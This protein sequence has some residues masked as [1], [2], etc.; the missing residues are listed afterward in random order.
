MS[1]LIY[2]S[3]TSIPRVF[4][5]Y[6]P[7]GLKC[8]SPSLLSSF[9]S[10]SH[11]VMS[12]SLQP[13]W[14]VARQAPLSMGFSRQEYWGGLSSPSPGDLPDSET[15]PRSP[16]LQASSLPYEPF[17]T[18]WA[19]READGVGSLSLLQR[20]FLTQES[21]QGLCIAVGF[22]TSW[23]IREAHPPSKAWSTNPLPWGL[24]PLTTSQVQ[25]CC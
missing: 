12:D 9:W 3:Q 21:N 11:S 7:L 2:V 8:T 14:T 18:S 15:E 23:A 10:L 17:F 24:L 19:T 4:H 20:I 6:S 5:A 1:N 13:P 16:A 22:F 25:V